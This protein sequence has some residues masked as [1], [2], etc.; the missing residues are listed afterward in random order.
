MM[1]IRLLRSLIAMTVLAAVVIGFP[2][3]LYKVA[4]SPLP[5]HVPTFEEIVSRL[6]SRDDG[7]LFVSVLGLLVWGAWAMF[8]FTV[9]TEIVARLRGVRFAPRQPGLGGVQRLAAY[10]VTSATFAFSAPAAMAAVTPPPPV[11]AMA[12][13]HPLTHSSHTTVAEEQ[14]NPVYQV[15]R[16]D[17]LWGIAGEKLGNPR[18]WP[19]IWKLN[20]RSPQP[21]GRVFTDPD[22][23]DAGWRL[24]LPEEPSA[25]IKP[26]RRPAP[27]STPAPSV[28]VSFPTFPSETPPEPIRP[29]QETPEAAPADQNS[30]L[31]DAIELPSGSLIAAAYAAGISTAYAANRFHRRRRRI[32][33]PASEGVT[34]TPEPGPAPAVREVLRAHRRVFTER[35][36]AVPSD[37]ELMRR[38]YSIDVPRS[39]AIGRRADRSPAHVDLA[40]LS[41]GLTGPGAHAVTRYL[42]VDLLRQSSN[43]RGEVVLCAALADDLFNTSAD[44]LERLAASIP[45]LIV[46]SS[47]EEALGRFEEAHFT[48]TRMLLERGTPGVGELREQDPGEALP[49]IFLVAALDDEVYTRAGTSLMSAQSTGMGALVLGAWPVGTTCQV[50]EDHRVEAAEGPLASHL[51]GVELFH[52]AADEAA[53]HLRELADPSVPSDPASEDPPP[54]SE[55]PLWGGPELIRLI[56]LGSPQVHVRDR[57]SSLELSWLQLNTLAYLALHPDGVTR[58]RLR[59]ALWPDDAGKDLH[60]TL[61]HLRVALVSATGY[62]APDGRR[63][64]FIN[65]STTKDSAAYRIDPQLISVDLWDYRAALEQVKTASD[66][67]VRLAALERAA[68][69]CRG[70]LAPGLDAEWI[71]EYR[72]PLV[73]SQADV[74][75]QLAE[76][77]EPDDPEHAM[78]GPRACPCPRPRQRGDLRTDRPPATTPRPARERPEDG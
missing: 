33:P 59:T 50:D 21:G 11:A 13:L 73:R 5:D 14:A 6:T 36:E 4:G 18:R 38:A 58:D 75:S 54:R 56:L 67:A 27:R 10:L 77:Y 45:G 68:E 34:I 29:I 55:P 76:L 47:P 8:S 1:L 74:L 53:A 24:R 28:Q 9:A 42:V 19:K 61:R 60:N 39:T 72:Y 44:E 71:E 26:T 41:L 2:I 22:R 51:L 49:A 3:L 70:E 66:P 37:A 31:G 23:I 57:F 64:P 65:A 17:T 78:G 52:T 69:L 63:A 16:G 25:E 35:G 15:K 30:Q 62:R 46:T 7:G 40:G 32:S 20:A 12:P 43:F 48:R